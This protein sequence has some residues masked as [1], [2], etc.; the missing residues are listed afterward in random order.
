MA[1]PLSFK[2][3]TGNHSNLI[4]AGSKNH[5]QVLLFAG[6]SFHGIFF[7]T[8]LPAQLTFPIIDSPR[9]EYF[10]NLLGSNMPAVH[11]APG[12][13]AVLKV[14]RMAVQATLVGIAV[15]FQALN[16]S[17]AGT[18]RGCAAGLPPA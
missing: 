17:R 3:N 2:I 11:T 14:R 1:G 12:M 5:P 7:T 10:S 18:A 15:G 8:F 16:N 6:I 9:S 13:L 4:I